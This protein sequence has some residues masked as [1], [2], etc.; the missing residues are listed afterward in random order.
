MRS[1]HQVVPRETGDTPD[2]ETHRSRDRVPLTTLRLARTGE[3]AIAAKEVALWGYRAFEAG[4]VERSLWVAIERGDERCGWLWLEWLNGRNALLH[5]CG[6]PELKHKAYARHVARGIGWI[7]ELMGAEQ[8]WV[9]AIGEEVVAGY[10]R[11]LGWREV[12]EGM[13]VQATRRDRGEW[14]T[15]PAT[16]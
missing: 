5:L 8:V 9:A 13:F 7:A 1:S 4:E 12:K 2:G 16:S 15:R 11:R 6:H 3:S 10:M 14:A